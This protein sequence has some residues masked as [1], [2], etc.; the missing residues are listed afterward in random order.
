[1][2]NEHIKSVPVCKIASAKYRNLLVPPYKEEVTPME[3]GQDFENSPVGLC[4]GITHYNPL[5]KKVHHRANVT[6][7]TCP[8]FST[9]M[10]TMNGN[11]FHFALFSWFFIL[12][13]AH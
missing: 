8:L 3:W 13:I 7:I 1:M 6:W 2:T 11:I 10:R 12:R 4:A 5:K 9:L